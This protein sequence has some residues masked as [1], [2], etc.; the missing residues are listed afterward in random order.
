MN[1]RMQKAWGMTKPVGFDKTGACRF[2][3]ERGISKQF[4]A[5]ENADFLQIISERLL[6]VRFKYS[7]LAVKSTG[8]QVQTE[9]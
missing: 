5:E 8:G 4:N 3:E 7:L 2:W 9:M 1:P 6:L